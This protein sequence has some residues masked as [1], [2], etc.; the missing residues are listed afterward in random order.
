MGREGRKGPGRAVWVLVGAG[1]TQN[2]LIAAIVCDSGDTALFFLLS[3]W[4]S[5][6][7]RQQGHPATGKTLVQGREVQGQEAQGWCG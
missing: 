1:A 3:L 2:D 5:D 4:M 7:E 6:L